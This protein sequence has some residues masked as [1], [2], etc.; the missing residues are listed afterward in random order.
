MSKSVSFNIDFV[1]LWVDGDD[2]KWLTKRSQYSHTEKQN[3]AVRFRDY[4][5][6]K[7]WFRAVAKYAP[8]VHRIYL[9]TDQQ[10]PKWLLVDHPKLRVI[11]HTEIMPKEALPTFNSNAI[12]LNIANIPGLSEH[13]VHF[14]DDM[15]LNHK[16]VPLD[17][18]S[19]KGL[20]KDSAVQ[21]AIMPVEDFDHMTANNMALIN[22]NFQKYEVLRQHPLRFFNFRYGLLNILSVCLLP[23]PRFTRFQD[24]HLPISFKKSVFKTVLKIHSEAVDVTTHERF[25]SKNDNTI[26]LIRYYQLVTAQFSPRRPF[27]GKKYN[28]KQMKKVVSDINV[29][30]HKMI[31]INDQV[32]STAD[33]DILTD[34]L[35]AAFQKKL[36]QK[37]EF[38]K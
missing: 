16:V 30:K 19:E 12:D 22:Q 21:N 24:P 36:P 9:V 27:I 4:G 34:Q 35:R 7:Y 20:P 6:F 33:F 18:F 2:K 10:V 38:E 11:D 3:N 37:C 13:F 15:Y 8:W 1:V 28:I 25:R 17:F 32:A 14:N 29:G 23:W 31:C 5:T 26:W